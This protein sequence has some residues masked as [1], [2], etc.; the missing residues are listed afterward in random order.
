MHMTLEVILLPVADVDRAKTFY[1]RM[2]F[3][4]DVDH[5]A[6]GFRVVQFTPPGSG[7]S[8][9]FGE[10]LGG[11]SRSPVV[12]MHLVV[13]DLAAALEELGS[14]GIEIGAP[15]HYG[16]GGKQPGI[17]PAH[18]DY[19]SYAELTDPD[20]NLWLIQEVPSRAGENTNR[21]EV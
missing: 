6:D 3:V 21:I 5:E 8:I 18:A 7:C 11:V 2:G 12:G 13:A 15:F 9:A 4:C 1:G 20:D 14:R 10:G 19:G 16:R 17:D